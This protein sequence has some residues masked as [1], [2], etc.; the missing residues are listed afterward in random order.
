MDKKLLAA[1]EKVKPI[2]TRQ[3]GSVFFC[4]YRAKDLGKKN[5]NHSAFEK[6]TRLAR[7]TYLRYGRVPLMDEYDKNAEV[8]LCRARDKF[9][10]EWLCLRF[11][12]SN[13]RAE[14]LEDLKH[15]F[16]Q[17]RSIGAF[18]KLKL[19]GG[20]HDLKN[21]LVAI[22][23]ICGVAPYAP[24]G[25]GTK[26]FGSLKYTAQS[27]ALINREFFSRHHFSFMVGVFRPE[28]LIKILH[29]GP[30]LV[31]CLPDAAAILGCNSK[32]IVLNRDF[33]AYR[34][35]GYFLN[36]SDLLKLLAKLTKEKKL[37]VKS[38]RYY[39]PGYFAGLKN[40][41]LTSRY[42]DILQSLRGVDKL[43]RARGRIYGAEL[44]GNELRSLVETAVADGPV[45]KIISISDWKK[46]LSNINL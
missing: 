46:Q 22:S 7:R 23:R 4:I 12:A 39:V 9:T 17:D 19:F 13:T 6:I 8:Y 26:F 2:K 15:Y 40:K 29:L 33:D 16:Y 28:L 25:K 27:F 34:F 37:S 32:E 38:I 36:I 42:A 1:L 11:V 35:P 3:I 45:L 30:D 18:I 24:G 5:W 43:L 21:K 31:L 44:T 41:F 20:T 14:S 10:E